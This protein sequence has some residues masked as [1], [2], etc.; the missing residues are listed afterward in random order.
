[1]VESHARLV[2]QADALVFV[3]PTWCWG[4]PAIMK[5]WIERVLVTGV[6]FR[7]DERSGRIKAN[8]RHVR[9]IV[10]DPDDLRG[11]RPA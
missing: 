9:R 8:L 3:Y 7:L 5:G 6:A 10:G 11:L 1:M 2:K 4:L